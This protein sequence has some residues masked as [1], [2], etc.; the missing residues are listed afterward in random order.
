MLLAAGIG[1]L[2]LDGKISKF[3][4]NLNELVM[5]ECRSVVKKAIKKGITTV[6]LYGDICDGTHLSYEAHG[7]L[8]EF[9]LEF[10]KVLF[11]VVMGNHD[12]YDPEHNSLNLLLKMVNLGV[13]PNLRIVAGE[14]Q[15]F[16]ERK[17][18][19]VTVH[20]WPHDKPVKRHL[21]VMHIEAKGTKWDT[22]R[23][24]EGGMDSNS[25]CAIGHL[26][27]A[28]RVRNSYFSGTLYQT[29]FGERPEK[30]WHLIK[31][32]GTLAD[33]EIQLVPHKPV[34]RLDNVV[35]KT[36]DE[37]H[38]FLKSA[39]AKPD[40]VDPQTV[41]YKIFVSTKTVVL[42]D[43]PF[44]SVPNVVKTNVFTSKKELQALLVEDLL[45]DD[46]SGQSKVDTENVLNEWM[47][48]NGIEPGLQ[49]RVLAKLQSWSNKPP[50]ST[51][52]VEQDAD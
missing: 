38:E 43:D 31:W 41:Y 23:D 32:T 49:S 21:N 20:P 37:Y 16:F 17:G 10:P 44:K 42:P 2:H 5:N 47:Q 34:F 3:I 4:P 39:T 19:P 33:S 26:H 8:L 35:I 52:A 11:I 50:T 7:L 27:T 25:L 28:Q 15:T 29:S 46:A 40:N 9:F 1:D 13:L 30:Y 14:P 51:S 12:Y 18:T 6:F 22:G 24:V 36:L 45:L 48:K